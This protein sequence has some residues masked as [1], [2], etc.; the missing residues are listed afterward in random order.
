M[1]M[2]AISKIISACVIQV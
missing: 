1:T 2:P